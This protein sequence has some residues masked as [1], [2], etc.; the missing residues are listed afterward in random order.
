MLELRCSR[1]AIALTLLLTFVARAEPSGMAPAASS[2]GP[3]ATPGRT[4]DPVVMAAGDIACGRGSNP[5]APCVQMATSNLV[6]AERPDAVLA[7]GDVQYECGEAT[8]FEAFFDPSWGRFRD[9]IHP[10]IGNH[11]YLVG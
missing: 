4:A 2:P 11:E 8:D 5:D 6:V 10:V 3:G 9:T 1:V 7:L